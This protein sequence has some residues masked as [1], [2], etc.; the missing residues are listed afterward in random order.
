VIQNLSDLSNFYKTTTSK[1]D[2]ILCSF[3]LDKFVFE[4]P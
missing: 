2:S 3:T 4:Y 1:S